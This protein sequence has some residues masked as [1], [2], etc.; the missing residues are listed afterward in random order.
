RVPVSRHE[1]AADREDPRVRHDLVADHGE[2]DRLERVDAA[3]AER[4]DRRA[5]RY[6]SLQEEQTDDGRDARLR[7]SPLV[8][9][10]IFLRAAGGVFAEKVVDDRL[11]VTD[12]PERVAEDLGRCRVSYREIG[13]STASGVVA[14]SSAQL[15]AWSA[16]SSQPSSPAMKCGL[17]GYSL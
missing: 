7:Q 1:Q 16:I 6:D 12:L 14:C 11:R 2:P 13:D 3:L 10:G 9:S 4:L 15:S 17:P 5:A 8:G